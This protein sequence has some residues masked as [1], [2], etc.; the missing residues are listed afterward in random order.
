MKTN[1]IKLKTIF[2]LW[3][4]TSYQTTTTEQV[5]SIS[6]HEH[7][8]H[9]VLQNVYSSTMS[10]PASTLIEA[11]IRWHKTEPVEPKFYICEPFYPVI[12]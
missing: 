2:C 11:D 9:R 8:G 12:F 1:C 4:S 3:L 7:G 6:H 10:T 5:L